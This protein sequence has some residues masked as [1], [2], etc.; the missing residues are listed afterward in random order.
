MKYIFVV[1]ILLFTLSGCSTRKEIVY[2]QDPQDI[3]HMKDLME[4][5]PTIEVNDVLNVNV[6]SIDDEVVKPFQKNSGNQQQIGGGQQN[7]TLRGYLVDIKGDIQFP[8]LGKIH[9]A[10]KTRSELEAFLTKKIKAYVTDAVVE[11]RLL[12]F[13]VTVLGEVGSPGV[14]DVEDGRISFPELIA[15]AGDVKYTGKRQNIVVIREKEGEKTIGYVDLT[16]SDV[17]KNPFYY[18]KQN[19]IVY[20]EPTYKQV[21]TAGFITSYTGLLSLGTTIL[22]LIILFTR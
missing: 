5:E 13:K 15:R 2:F 9:V 3:D 14:I 18:L 8:V 19:D 17:F 20:V 16:S 11:V 6:S 12:N 21:K 4:F 10:G 1:F 7:P 22:S